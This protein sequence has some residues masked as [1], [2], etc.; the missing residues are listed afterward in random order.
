MSKTCHHAQCGLLRRI[1]Q[2]VS[3]HQTDFIQNLP[4]A[5]L[6]KAGPSEESS[7]KILQSCGCSRLDM[8]VGQGM[9]INSTAK[10]RPNMTGHINLATTLAIRN[11]PA[12]QY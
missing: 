6:Y 5:L 2:I 11:I 7:Q 9:Y 4:N 10:Q 3:G 8:L 1:C 12:I